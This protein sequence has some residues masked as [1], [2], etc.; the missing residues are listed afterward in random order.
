MS[1]KNKATLRPLGV[2]YR[3]HPF[4]RGQPMLSAYVWLGVNKYTAWG[5]VAR[6][7]EMGKFQG[8]SEWSERQGGST[9][10]CLDG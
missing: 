9:F 10:L 3:Y 4:V 5:C 6:S 1:V 2:S 7:D 8:L